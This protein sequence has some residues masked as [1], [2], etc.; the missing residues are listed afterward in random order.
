[1]RSALDAG[2]AA[3][4]RT[5]PNPW[6]GCVIVRDGE[7]VGAGATQPPG[8]PHAEVEALRA[9]GERARGATAYV[10]LEPCAHHGRTPPCVDALVQAGVARVVVAVEDPDPHVAGRGV[11]RLREHGVDVVV[12]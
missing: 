1:M 2:R 9:A 8:G 6:V 3:R 12:G 10:T 11:A 7:V 4:P 5:A